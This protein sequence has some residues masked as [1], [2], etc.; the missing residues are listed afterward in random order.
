MAASAPE[1]WRDV[2]LTNRDALLESLRGFR[3]EL[4]ALEA[5]VAAG[6]ADAIER[7]FAEG[8]AAKRGWGAV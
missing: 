2:C 6:D 1:L 8:A 5:A 7:F 3:A 4:D